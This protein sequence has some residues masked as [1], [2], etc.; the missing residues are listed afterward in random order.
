ML[1]HKPGHRVAILILLEL[2][3]DI[4]EILVDVAERTAAVVFDGLA[5]IGA[6][7][8]EFSYAE[9]EFDGTSSFECLCICAL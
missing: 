6:Y 4:R 7:L 8:P 9:A 5:V 3:S 2:C 1:I